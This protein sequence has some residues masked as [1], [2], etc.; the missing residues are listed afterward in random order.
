MR[1]GRVSSGCHP[2]DEVFE[3][4]FYRWQEGLRRL[5]RVGETAD[6][7]NQQRE[8]KLEQLVVELSLDKHIWQGVPAKQP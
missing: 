7:A 5:G 4:T 8:R 6:S 3:Q 2:P 1:D